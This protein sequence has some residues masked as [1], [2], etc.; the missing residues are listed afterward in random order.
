MVY[1]VW[2]VNRHQN[3]INYQQAMGSTNSLIVVLF[4]GVWYQFQ[5]IVFIQ[6][7]YCINQLHVD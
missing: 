7:V 1:K 2:G 4:N 3:N 5:H 6:A